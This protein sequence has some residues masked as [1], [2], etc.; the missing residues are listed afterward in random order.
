MEGAGLEVV[1]P[2]TPYDD[3]GCL[4]QAMRDNDPVMYVEHRILHFQKG[5]VP[6]PLYAVAPGK[7][8]I[9]AP[10][11]D[12]TL[13]GISHMQLECLRARSYL[14]SAGIQAELIDP[15]WLS[16]LGITTIVQPV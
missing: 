3:K 15:L 2:T 16:P 6:E 5:P 13:V 7:A 14:Q 10:G 1:A 4:V 11:S 8:R 9:T 12:V